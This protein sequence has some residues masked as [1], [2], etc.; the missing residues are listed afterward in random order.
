MNVRGNDDVPHMKLWSNQIYMYMCMYLRETIRWNCRKHESYAVQKYIYI[1][2]KLKIC[3]PGTDDKA[4]VDLKNRV[5]KIYF[6]KC[7]MSLRCVIEIII[8][9]QKQLLCR[10]S[11]VIL[12]FF[13]FF[14]TLSQF[15]K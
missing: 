10:A 5:M 1:V 13:F 9:C 3:S 4:M 11:D 7:E 6:R 12:Y 8:I 14:T 2:I 15:N